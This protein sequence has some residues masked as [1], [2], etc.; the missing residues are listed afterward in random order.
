MFLLKKVYAYLMAVALTFT[1]SSCGVFSPASQSTMP[2]TENTSQDF[3]VMVPE[4][5]ELEPGF[6]TLQ[7]DGDYG[8]DAFLTQGGAS[9][10]Q[11]VLQFVHTFLSGDDARTRSGDIDLG[12]DASGDFFG[13]STISVENTEGGYWFG[14]NFD[15]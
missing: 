1:V 15:W 9:S 13:C 5:L 10:D 2:E 12:V 14:R 11:E 4:M 3:N 7:Y 6:S 8:F